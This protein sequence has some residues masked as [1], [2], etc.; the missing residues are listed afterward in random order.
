MALRGCS[1]E[2][3]GRV[4]VRMTLVKGVRTVK[5]AFWQLLTARLVKVTARRG[6]RRLQE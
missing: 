1:P 5:H 4:S 6:S 2:V 3:A